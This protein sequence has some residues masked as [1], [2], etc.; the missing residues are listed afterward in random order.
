MTLWANTAEGGTSGSAVPTSSD[1][2]GD[3]WT[4]V[5][6]GSGAITYDSAAAYKGA[7]GIKVAPASAS[8]RCWFGW[9]PASA[10]TTATTRFYFRMPSLPAAGY[11]MMRLSNTGIT[12]PRIALLVN[13]TG[14]MRISNAAGAYVNAYSGT[15]TSTGSISANTWYRV[16]FDIDVSGGTSAGIINLDVYSGDSTTPLSGLSGAITGQNFATTLPMWLFGRTAALT[17]TT[18]VQFDDLAIDTATTT[19]IGPT[20]SGVNVSAD[21]GAGAA[22]ANQPRPQISVTPAT[23]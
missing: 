22:A 19:R 21:Y 11:E 2:S 23:A 8:E 14:T 3:A 6:A 10:P 7:L 1:G 17:D 13:G 9:T 15:S 20:A 18:V 5:S 16:E 4:T 12:A